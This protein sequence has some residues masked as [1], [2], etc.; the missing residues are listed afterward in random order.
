MRRI[1]QSSEQWLILS[2]SNRL[3]TWQLL[4][5]THFT[6]DNLQ[7]CV[8]ITFHQSAKAVAVLTNLS[9]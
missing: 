5:T 4:E 3:T 1:T 8:S 2:L 9:A 6:E 7:L